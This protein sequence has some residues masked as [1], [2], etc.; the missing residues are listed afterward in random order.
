[1]EEFTAINKNYLWTGLF[2]IVQ[3]ILDIDIGGDIYGISWWDLSKG[4]FNPSLIRS[5]QNIHINETAACIY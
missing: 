1:M 4:N 5:Q 3:T 2:F